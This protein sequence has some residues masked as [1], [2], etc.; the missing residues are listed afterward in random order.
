MRRTLGSFAILALAATLVTACGDGDD[1]AAPAA[2]TTST[3]PG[4]AAV[5]DMTA[6]DGRALG[7]V[8]FVESSG[9]LIVD[10]RLVDLPPGFH[11][12]HVHAVG[13]CE[14]GAP[15]FTSAGGHMVTGTQAHP[16]HAGDQPVLLVLNDGSSDIRFTTDR[17]TLADLLHPEGRAVIVHANPDN[18]GNI[19]TRYAP[20]VD[21]MTQATGDAGD[22]IACGV[23]RRP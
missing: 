2:Q 17:Y 23:V 13:K 6:P 8:S 10:G 18:Y 1:D 11:G 4:P 12:F 5:A 16:V 14:P 20:Q 19:P 22:R 3:T 15:P 21:A 7:R 9:R